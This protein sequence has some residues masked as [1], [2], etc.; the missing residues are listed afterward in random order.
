MKYNTTVR[1]WKVNMQEIRITN[2]L[3]ESQSLFL[4][5]KIG[6]SFKRV[7]SMN[8]GGKLVSGCLTEDYSGTG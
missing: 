6:D 4:I 8:A 7:E 5:F 1:E 2:L 3:S